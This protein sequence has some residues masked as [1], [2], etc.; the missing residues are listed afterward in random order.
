M[1][2]QWLPGISEG[3]VEEALQRSCDDQVE[4]LRQAATLTCEEDS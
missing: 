4:A 2:K 1:T 3:Q